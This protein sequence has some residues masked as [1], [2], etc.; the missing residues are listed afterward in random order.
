MQAEGVPLADANLAFMLLR[1]TGTRWSIKG[2]GGCARCHGP[3][4]P[5][6]WRPLVK[7]EDI[8]DLVDWARNERLS[9]S[10][11]ESKVLELIIEEGPHSTVSI[12]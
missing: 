4:T 8:L 3:T 1:A 2:Y 10:E 5:L 6:E 9:L 12:R 11:I 7:D